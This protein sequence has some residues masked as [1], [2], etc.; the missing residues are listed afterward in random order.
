[1]RYLIYD[2]ECDFCCNVVRILTSLVDKSVVTY[3][4]LKSQKT[5]ELINYHN[6]QNINSVI[7]I[8]DK[9]KIYIKAIAVLNVFRIMNFPYNLLYIF[10]ILPESFLNFIYD[11]IAKNR[12]KIK[13]S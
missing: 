2:D 10:N 1:M 12:M 4:P 6:L 5:K 9:D 3:L 13:R 11:F 8:D 7:Y